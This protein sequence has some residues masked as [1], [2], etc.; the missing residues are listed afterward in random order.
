MLVLDMAVPESI[1]LPE[2]ITA[3]GPHLSAAGAHW[4]HI[5]PDRLQQDD[6]G[7][8][9]GFASATTDAAAV[10]TVPNVG[11]SRYAAGQG[12]R[13]LPERYCGFK[14]SDL[15]IDPAGWTLAIRL[16]PAGDTARTLLTLR[17]EGVDNYLFLQI[18]DGVAHFKDD[19][20]T[21]EVNR[22]VPAVAAPL[23]VMVGLA[24]GRLWLR[25]GPGAVARAAAGKRIEMAP[26]GTLFVGCRTDRARLL[27]MSGDFTLCDVVMWPAD[28]L[29]DPAHDEMRGALDQ[30]ALWEAGP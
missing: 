26:R 23:L 27:K 9:T 3:L 1:L 12:L 25:V 18:V 28:D 22:P 2:P 21:Q 8:V 19:K 15:A 14:I 16:V 6:D 13:F 30:P 10:A 4:F 29:S 20:S 7:A 24:R 17:P 5:H 11:N